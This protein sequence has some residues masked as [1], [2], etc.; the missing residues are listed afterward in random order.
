MTFKVIAEAAAKRDWNEA[1]EWYEERESGV[2]LQ[3][4]DAIRKFLQTLSRK[5]ERFRFASRL[6]RKAK[7]PGPWPYSIYFVINMEFREVKVLAIWHGAR[8]PAQLRRRLK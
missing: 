3:L 1:V 4:D 5:P 8:N 7:V 6:S 2:G